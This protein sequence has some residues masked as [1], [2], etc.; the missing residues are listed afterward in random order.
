MR[1]TPEGKAI[2]PRLL[3]PLVSSARKTPGVLKSGILSSSKKS[4][5]DKRSSFSGSESERS[6]AESPAR[7]LGQRG[8]VLFSP[9]SNAPLSEHCVRLLAHS[10]QPHPPLTL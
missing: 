2:S 9:V 3:S 6:V 10:E 1:A 7:P 5:R 8:G 4:A